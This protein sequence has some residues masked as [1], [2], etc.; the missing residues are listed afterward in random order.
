MPMPVTPLTSNAGAACVWPPT[1]TQRARK[2]AGGFIDCPVDYLTLPWWVYQ[3]GAI[4][5]GTLRFWLGTLELVEKRCCTDPD[6]PVYYDP[7]E[8]RRLLHVP[9]LEPVR[10][11]LQRLEDLGLLAW[12]PP[13]IQFLPHARALREAL[14]QDSYQTLRAQLAPG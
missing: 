7:E 13:A 1:G 4:A 3:Q 10:A 2:S 11:A 6:A 5:L 9:R 14:T 12:S 8:L